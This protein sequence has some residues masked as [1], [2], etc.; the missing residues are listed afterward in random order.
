MVLEAG[1]LKKFLCQPSQ[2]TSEA[3]KGDSL[4][5]FSKWLQLFLGLWEC[6]SNISFYLHMPSPCFIQ[7]SPSRFLIR[8]PIIGLRAHLKSRMIHLNILNLITLA[9]TLSPNKISCTSSEGTDLDI[10]F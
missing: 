6:E 8:T 7:V 3:S 1:S 9:K 10:H 5:A 4:L 2:A